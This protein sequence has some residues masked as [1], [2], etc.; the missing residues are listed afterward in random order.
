LNKAQT[1]ALI[2][3][4]I[5]LTLAWLFPPFDIPGSEGLLG[6]ESEYAFI[7][8]PPHNNYGVS[9][10]PVEAV[11]SESFLILTVL[12]IAMIVCRDNAPLRQKIPAMI[13]LFISVMTVVDGFEN[14]A[15]VGP[16]FALVFI[17]PITLIVVLLMGIRC[18]K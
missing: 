4:V 11:R 9:V 12:T 15:W 14:P 17:A 6:A 1:V 16:F 5:L 10:F 13:S 3:G 7:T 8:N 18:T 2:V